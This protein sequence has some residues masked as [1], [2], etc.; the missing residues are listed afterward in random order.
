MQLK[1]EAV[2][3]KQFCL[4]RSRAFCP[5]RSGPRLTKA[6]ESRWGQA[7]NL[8]FAGGHGHRPAGK[9]L[10]THCPALV[11]T[12]RLCRVTTRLAQS[13]CPEWPLPQEVATASL[14]SRYVPNPSC[15]AAS[16]NGL[17][18]QAA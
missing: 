17:L 13:P 6:H 5:L 7:G 11:W 14:Y 3:K 18:V 8:R 9:P 16:Q 12:G 1:P 2:T 4:E 15:A 10:R